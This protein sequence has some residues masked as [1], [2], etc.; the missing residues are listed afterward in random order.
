MCIHPLPALHWL[1]NCTTIQFVRARCR[2]QPP[3]AS[4][5]APQLISNLLSTITGL[6]GETLNPKPETRRLP[7]CTAAHQQP[8][9]NH[10]RLTW[11]CFLTTRQL[12]DHPAF[13]RSLTSFPNALLH[14]RLD[15]DSLPQDSTSSTPWQSW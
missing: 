13:T 12:Y 3:A 11:H 1:H 9:F 2:A 7:C 5:A 15:S 6:L 14:A 8:A 4:P 10:K